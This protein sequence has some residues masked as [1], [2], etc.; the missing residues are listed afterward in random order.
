MHGE[1]W[2]DAHNAEAI[3]GGRSCLPSVEVEDWSVVVGDV[4]KLHVGTSGNLL[5]DVVLTA[6]THL[7]AG[8]L[9]ALVVGELRLVEAAVVEAQ[10]DSVFK[11]AVNVFVAPTAVCTK[12]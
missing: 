12:V 4:V 8:F 2:R 1:E 10:V 7:Y 11:S 3:V 6:K 9:H 5:V